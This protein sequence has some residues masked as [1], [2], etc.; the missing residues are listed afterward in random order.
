LRAS[1]TGSTAWVR[2]SQSR[3]RRIPVATAA[4]I[5]RTFAGTFRILA[6]G[7]PMKIVIPAIAPR[8]RVCPVL[9]LV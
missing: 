5:V 6:T 8:R 7:R 4:S 9:I 3:K 2:T 1:S